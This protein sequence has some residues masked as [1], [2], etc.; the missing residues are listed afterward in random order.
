MSVFAQSLKTFTSDI[1]GE[2]VEYKIN[3][4]IW[5][6]LKGKFGLTQKDFID[7]SPEEENIYSAKFVTA[8]MQANGMK[9]TE[10]EVNENVDQV[11]LIKFVMEYN[12][13][14]SEKTAKI[15]GMD[16][17]EGPEEEIEGK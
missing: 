15:F 14:I 2:E 7:K 17:T 9:V 1:T 5:V 6:I 8:V 11:D 13:A 16:D 10:K 12:K 4:A 3:N